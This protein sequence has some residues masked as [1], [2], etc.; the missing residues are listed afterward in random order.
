[1]TCT[2]MQPRFASAS[3]LYLHDGRL[4]TPE[5]K[6]EFF[7]LIDGTKLTSQEKQQSVAFLRAL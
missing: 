7:S 4:P 2:A 3:P 5:D 6:V 1:M